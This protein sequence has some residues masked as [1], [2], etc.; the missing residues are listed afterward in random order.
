MSLFSRLFD[1]ILPFR[2]QPHFNPTPT[3]VYPRRRVGLNNVPY[4]VEGIALAKSLGVTQ[5]RDTVY[6]AN[7]GDTRLWNEA[8]NAFD[9][10]N[11]HTVAEWW[12]IH[13]ERYLVAG[14]DVLE[15][16]HTPPAGMTLADGITEMPAFVAAKAAQFPG[17]TWQIMN[18]MDANIV[19]DDWFHVATGTQTERGQL[20]GSLLG[21]VYDAVKAADSTA[22]VVAGGI[23]FEPT[24][25]FSGLASV[26][27][28]KYDAVCIHCYRDPSDPLTEGGQPGLTVPFNAKSV[29]MRAVLGSTPLWCTETGFHYDNPSTDEQVRQIAAILDENDRNTRYDRVYLY[30]MMDE[31][32]H[33]GLVNPN[34]QRRHAAMLLT[35]RT[36]V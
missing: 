20:Y 28:G 12:A 21:P 33:Y 18:E 35:E 26:A 15:V 31:A 32:E 14:F 36:A 24:A 19:N 16:V 25:F 27:P 4:T 29:A 11:G 17:L 7:H 3:V 13:V 22:T 6:W 2:R 34:G 10:V 9:P 30:A 8:L 1:M 23:A 5:I